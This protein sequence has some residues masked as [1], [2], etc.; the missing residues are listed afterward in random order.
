M[1]ERQF[2]KHAI[3]LEKIIVNEA[4]FK[5]V[6]VTGTPTIPNPKFL[7]GKSEYDKQDHKISI[8]FMVKIE[9]E[10][11]GYICTVDIVGL[12]SVNESEFNLSDLDD[13]ADTN[14]PFILLPYARQQVLNLTT[15]ATGEGFMLP[16]FEVPTSGRP[17]KK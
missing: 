7:I 4:S 1:N 11:F 8:G 14:A 12:F 3:Q 6:E 15:N 13:W 16:L 10:N 17:L 5:L 2:K 9:G